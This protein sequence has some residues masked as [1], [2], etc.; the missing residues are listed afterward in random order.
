MKVFEIGRLSENNCCIN[1]STVS[2]RHA[3]LTLDD[4]GQHGTLRDLNSSQGT[5][6]NGNPQRIVGEVRV[7]R[8]DVIR[9]GS[10]VT[11]IDGIIKMAN[12]TKFSKPFHGT[13]S[14]QDCKTIGKSPENQIVLNYDDVS[15]KHAMIYK[16]STGSIIIEDLNSTNG[17]YVNGIKV[18][19]KKLVAGDKVT[20]TRNYPIEWQSLFGGNVGPSPR[21]K[22][23]MGNWLKIAAAVVLVALIGGGVYVLYDHLK[24][25]QGEEVVEINKEYIY[26][27]YHSAV[28]WVLVEYGYQVYVDGDNFTP[29]LCQYCE[30]TP[31]ETVHIEGNSLVGGTIGAEGTAFFISKDGKLATNLHVSRPWLFSDDAETLE[32]VTNQILAILA[33]RNPILT[34]SKVE[35][36]GVVE[37]MYIIPDCLPVSQANAVECEEYRG[38]N[39]IEKDVAVLQTKTRKLP[40]GVTDI[41]DID[42]ANVTED[43]LTE[44][45]T[46]YTIGY[47]YGMDVAM[48]SNE[49]LKNQVHEG[50]IT[51]NRGDYEFGHDAATAGGASGSPIWNKEGELIGIHHAGMTGVTGAQGFN[52]AIKAKYLLELIK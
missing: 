48:D 29:I 13:Q 21:E 17:T 40:E 37:G 30:I 2:R 15:R 46:V 8:K 4:D 52:R 43:A 19:S 42:N 23:S 5:Y 12:Q 31:R 24:K 35:V 20:I 51:Q 6:V 22:S 32:S 7:S 18:T 26:K 47:P 50:S 9:F 41:V 11:N 49:N 45:R 14:G 10:E 16:D 39:D 44:G 27:K 28:C 3:T 33:T 38:H 34:R 36:K 1:N 25:D